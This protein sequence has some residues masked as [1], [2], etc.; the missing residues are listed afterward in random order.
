[1]YFVFIE[2]TESVTPNS[3]AE[4]HFYAVVQRHVGLDRRALVV[5]TDPAGRRRRRRGG[6]VQ[7]FVPQAAEVLNIRKARGG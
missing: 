5:R 6:R 2:L 7:L 3:V 1:M 4:T